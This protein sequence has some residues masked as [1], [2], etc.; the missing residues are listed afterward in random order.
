[1]LIVRGRQV[2]KARTFRYAAIDA[3]IVTVRIAAPAISN[4]HCRH[5]CS[6]R[7][8]FPFATVVRSHQDKSSS[9]SDRA[10]PRKDS[11]G[12]LDPRFKMGREI[13]QIVC[14]RADNQ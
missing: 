9:A 11:T 3:Y 14:S 1:M 4:Q 5:P 8:H 12:V 2:T 10:N 7:A 13:L 6:A